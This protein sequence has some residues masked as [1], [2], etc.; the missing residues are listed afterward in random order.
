MGTRRLHRLVL[1]RRALVAG[2]LLTV[3]W[4][5]RAARRAGVRTPSRGYLITGV[6]LTVLAVV[7]PRS[8]GPC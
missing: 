4:Y 8:T 1:D 5:W 7:L 6:V 2:F 3:L